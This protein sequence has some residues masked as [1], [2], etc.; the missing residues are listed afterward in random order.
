MT[1]PYSVPSSQFST[2]Q[3]SET[4]FQETLKSQEMEPCRASGSPATISQSPSRRISQKHPVKAGNRPASTCT[5]PFIRLFLSLACSA[6]Q[7]TKFSNPQMLKK[8]VLP[9][10]TADMLLG[11]T[12]TQLQMEPVG[13]LFQTVWSYFIPALLKD[14]G[15]LYIS[16]SHTASFQG[17][18][19]PPPP[20]PHTGFS[21]ASKE[22]EVGV[23]SCNCYVC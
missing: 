2:T 16:Q 5:H 23:P 22:R 1:K 13:R 11:V 18:P 6:L 14:Q 20:P 15:H 17:A 8:K 10:L 19:P 3:M 7:R 12:P 9:L 4:Q 21:S